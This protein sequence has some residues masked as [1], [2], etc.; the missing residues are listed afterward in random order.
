MSTLNVNGCAINYIVE[1][2]G[3]AVMLIHVRSRA[4]VA[5]LTR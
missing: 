3:A 5:W 4:I 2:T 1:G